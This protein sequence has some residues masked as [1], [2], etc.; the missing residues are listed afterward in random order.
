MID[1]SSKRVLSQDWAKSAMVSPVVSGTDDTKPLSLPSLMPMTCSGQVRTKPELNPTS[2]E[3]TRNQQPVPGQTTLPTLNNLSLLQL[4]SILSRT[5]FFLKVCST[6]HHSFLIF[7]RI[8]RI[9]PKSEASHFH[10]V[11]VYQ[12][13]MT[14]LF[15]RAI[16]TVEGISSCLR[17]CSE[18]TAAQANN[19]GVWAGHTCMAGW[20]GKVGKG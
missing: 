7:M 13:N 15:E 20:Q 4:P 1:D 14:V 18:K 11:L 16:Q 19:L 6:K 3:L 8:S 2:A 17:V 10:K 9:L 12:W 5:S